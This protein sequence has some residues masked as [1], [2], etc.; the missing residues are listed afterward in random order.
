MLQLKGAIIA[1]ND[2][3]RSIASVL[4]HLGIEPGQIMM[5]AICKRDHK[6]KR[7]SNRSRRTTVL[8]DLIEKTKWI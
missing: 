3:S 2:G 7:E 1:F 5:S 4:K 6:C 8:E